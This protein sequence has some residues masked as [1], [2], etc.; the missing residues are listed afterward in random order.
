MDNKLDSKIN[1]SINNLFKNK[2]NYLKKNIKLNYLIKIYSKNYIVNYL[3]ELMSKSINLYK[4]FEKKKPKLI[5]SKRSSNLSYAVGEIANKLNLDSILISHA[6]HIVNK[7]KLS[8]FD[9]IINSKSTI[10]SDYKFVASQSKFSGQF[11]KKIDVK[12]KII[13]TGPI[14]LT[15]PSKDYV[16]TEN[17][18]KKIILQASTPKNISNFRPINYETINDYIENIRQQI[19]ALNDKKNVFIIIKFREYNFLKLEDFKY[20]LPKTNNYKIDTYSS[21]KTLLYGCD[22]LS[23]YSSTVIEEAIFFKKDIILYDKNNLYKHLTKKIIHHSNY[24]TSKIY[25]CKNQSEL[26]K[27]F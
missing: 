27:L 22:Y 13:N 24:E 3:N 21:L 1:I 8:M 26:K 4:L 17:K 9:W 15:A 2:I 16:N 11:L 12:S 18:K 7:N 23:S 5:I 19:I 10:N 6:S 25:Y 20:L 14:I